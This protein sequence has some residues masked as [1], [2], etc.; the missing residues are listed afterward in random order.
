MKKVENKNLL[1]ENVNF[2]NLNSAWYEFNHQ[3]EK[4]ITRYGSFWSDV[5][6]AAKKY[7][8]KSSNK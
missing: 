5:V 6:K 2:K 7:R 1:S 4:V 8:A 3:G